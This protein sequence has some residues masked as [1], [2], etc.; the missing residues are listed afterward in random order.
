MLFHVTHTTRYIYPTP[1]SH[2]LNE[3][4]LTPRSFSGQ[5]VRETDIQVDPAPAFIRRRQDY[6]GNDV[7]SFEVFEKHERLEATAT[8]VVEV[9]SAENRSLPEI[10]WEEVRHL[11][12]AQQDAGSLAASEFVFD[13][14]FVPSVPQL[15]E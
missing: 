9:Q 2:G 1:V 12:A 6:Y 14:P 8:S 3:V 11:I 15:N 13:S 5:N 4:R 7:I 10:S